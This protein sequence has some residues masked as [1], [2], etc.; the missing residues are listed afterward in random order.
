MDNNNK[1]VSG[2]EVGTTSRLFVK[3]GIAVSLVII[4]LFGFLIYRIGVIQAN[5]TYRNAALEQYTHEM[6][7][8]AKRGDILDRNGQPLANNMTVYNCFISPADIETEDTSGNP[9]ETQRE[10]IVTG[11]A[12]ILSVDENEIRKQALKTNRKYEV[13]KKSISEEEEEA[14]RAFITQNGLSHCV[15]LEESS[16]R[17]YPN[18]TLA[19]HVLGYTGSENKGLAGLELTYNDYLS[20]VNGRVVKATDAKGNEINFAYSNYVDAV[21]GYNI[22]TTLD[23]SIQSMLE[24]YLKMAYDET[25]PTGSVT[26]IICDVST[27]EVLAMANYPNYDLN[28]YSVLT[29]PYLDKL[30]LFEGTDE[31]K[32]AY[33]QE[34]RATMWK[35]LAVSSTYEPGST[36]KLVSGAI[37]LDEGCINESTTFECEGRYIIAGVPIRCHVYGKKVHGTQVFAEAIYNS[38][39]PAFI[40]ISQKIGIDTFEEY[41]DLFGYNE[42]INSDFQGEASSIFF[43]NM[44]IVDLANASF[45]QAFKVTPIQHLRALCTV[46]NGGNLI[47]PH[48]VK[49]VVDDKGNVIETTN[50]GATRQV[51]SSETCSVIM[52]ALVNSTKNACV[53]GYNVVSKTGTSQKLDTPKEDDYVLSCVTFAPAEDPKIAILVLVD[54]PTYTE[55]TMFGGSIAAPIVS[56]VLAEVLPYMGILPTEAGADVMATVKDYKNDDLD[57][58]KYDIERLGLK[59]VVYGSGNTVIDQL[60][61]AGTE[62]NTENGVVV[63]YTEGNSSDEM[64][65]MPDLSDMSPERVSQVLTSRKL[66]ISVSGIFNDTYANC[67]VFS[68]SIP[69]GTLVAPGTVVHVEFRYNEDIE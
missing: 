24:K 2:I 67:Y 61:R 1:R 57:T 51:V 50:Y 42:K 60:P 12:R 62:L 25:K 56:N 47:T 30:S 53:N 32:T 6:V 37:A 34:L 58:A 45:G 52:N 63:L 31:E 64:I 59:A 54:D 68:Q 17:Y 49:E 22:V 18:S 39:N 23:V 69:A 3:R 43:S 36:F 8:Y 16:K 27:G 46:A 41:Y 66:N 11:L 4:L 7:I 5:D 13:I 9:S 55:S 15:H 28:N 38:C 40:Q 33:E 44:G 29:Q 65:L 10:T 14:V 21:D 26:G 20:G 19:S 48:L 35:N